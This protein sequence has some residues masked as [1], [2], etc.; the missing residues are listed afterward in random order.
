MG[1]LF[2]EG[3]GAD[4]LQQLHQV[5]PHQLPLTSSHSEVNGGV[6]GS[7]AQVTKE[8]KTWNP[9]EDSFTQMAEDHLF[10]QEFDKIRQ[11]GSQ[12]SEYRMVEGKIFGESLAYSYR[13]TH[14]GVLIQ[15]YILLNFTL[16][17]NF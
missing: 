2:A 6:I 12:T 17:S 15:E 14:T 11:Q 9:F 3:G 13:S 1:G 7:T 16:D 5:R 4:Q 8:V 10:G